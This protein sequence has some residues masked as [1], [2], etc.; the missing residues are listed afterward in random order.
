MTP[1]QH[2]RVR[3]D[4]KLRGAALLRLLLSLPEFFVASL[5]PVPL[6]EYDNE[7]HEPGDAYTGPRDGPRYDWRQRLFADM[8]AKQ[9]EF[10]AS[11][12]MKKLTER[13]HLVER[14]LQKRS[15]R[16]LARCAK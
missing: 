1:L 2:R 10:L 12:R 15:R 3:R 6:D 13:T 9:N 8:T 4:D 7:R 14:Q 16:E 11:K 5:S